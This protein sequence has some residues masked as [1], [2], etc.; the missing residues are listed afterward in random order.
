[1]SV[2]CFMRAFKKSTGL[3]FIEYLNRLRIT[4]ALTLLRRNELSIN[5]IGFLCGYARQDYFTRVFKKLTKTTP[6][7]LREAMH[8]KEDPQPFH[9]SRHGSHTLAEPQMEGLT[10]PFPPLFPTSANAQ[11]APK[12]ILIKSIFKV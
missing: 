8:K 10:P 12:S 1:M 4:H 3:T 7:A 9:T 5:E 2:S 6:G 11:L